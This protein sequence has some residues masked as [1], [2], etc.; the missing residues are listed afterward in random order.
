MERTVRDHMN[1]PIVWANAGETCRDALSRMREYSYSQ[2]PVEK[3]GEPVGSITELGLRD[4]DGDMLVGAVMDDPFPEI[5]GDESVDEAAR[6]LE[7]NSALLV[8]ED[9]AYIGIITK[10]DLIHSALG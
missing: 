1:Q 6:V 4:K 2:L 3:D 5:E 7:D 10:A 8:T 9:G